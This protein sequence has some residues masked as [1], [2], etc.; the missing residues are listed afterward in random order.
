[1]A[2]VDSRIDDLYK[3]PLQEFV[4]LR[5]GLAKTLTGP[6]A[7]RVK[8]LPKPTIVPWAVNQLYWRARPVYDRLTESG[9]R[10]RAVQIAGLEGRPADVRRATEAHRQA[11]ADAVSEALAL[12]SRTGEHPNTDALVQT[13]EALSLA[14]GGVEVPGRLTKPLRPAGFEALAGVAIQAPAPAAPRPRAV[15]APRPQSSGPT[16]EERRQERLRAAAEARHA[17][18]IREAETDLQKAQ[19]TEVRARQS[20]ERAQAE[21]ERAERALE[22]LKSGRR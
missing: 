4:L 18:A 6:D 11:L 10:L 3:A 15:P 2:S 7:K 17:K 5:A 20:W 21:V 14:D 19:A 13:L 9:A 22:A 8:A 1:M 12:A 16:P